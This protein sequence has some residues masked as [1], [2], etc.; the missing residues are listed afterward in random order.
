MVPEIFFRDPS[1]RPAIHQK[2]MGPHTS[3]MYGRKNPIHFRCM[4][5]WSL[6]S[7][8]FIF[9]DHKKFPYDNPRI[10]KTQNFL[11]SSGYHRENSHG[12]KDFFSR[13]E[14]STGHTSKMY[15]GAPY[16]ENVWEKKSHTFSMYGVLVSRVTKFYFPGP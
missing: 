2:C 15:P 10:S 7:R 9:W 1:D 13:P 4:G 12:P 3:K 14:Q 5:Y 6:G 16:I 8:N 11:K